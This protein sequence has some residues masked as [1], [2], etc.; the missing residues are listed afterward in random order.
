M[1][2]FALV[3]MGIA[4]GASALEKDPYA[5]VIDPPAEIKL[6]GY[7]KCSS[8]FE[9]ELVGEEG[10]GPFYA[11][12]EEIVASI[13]SIQMGMISDMPDTLINHKYKLTKKIAF[14]PPPFFEKRKAKLCK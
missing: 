2:K 5:I 1:W 9:L 12:A 14:H 7:N 3:L 11:S 6:V 8:T 10:P 13:D 4:F